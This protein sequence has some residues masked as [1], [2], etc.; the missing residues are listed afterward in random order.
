ML[1]V[2]PDSLYNYSTFTIYDYEYVC[3]PVLIFNRIKK[4]LKKER[5]LEY[6]I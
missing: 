4:C 5:L 2:G 3:L 1:R 6:V